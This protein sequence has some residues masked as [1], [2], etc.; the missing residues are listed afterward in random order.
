MKT[1][2]RIK[3]VVEVTGLSKSTIYQFVADGRFP[4]PVQLGPRAVGW[5]NSDVQQWIDRLAKKTQLEKR[6]ASY[7]CTQLV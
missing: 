7:L 1:I 6:K 5:L 2:L 3:A 4:K